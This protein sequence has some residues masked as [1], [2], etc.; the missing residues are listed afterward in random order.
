MTS[1]KV[2][3]NFRASVFSIQIHINRKNESYPE[4]AGTWNRDKMTTILKLGSCF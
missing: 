2:K 3:L 4:I 1:A